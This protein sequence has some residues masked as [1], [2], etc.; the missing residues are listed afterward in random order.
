MIFT[1]KYFSPGSKYSKEASGLPARGER[2]AG[3][4]YLKI[5]SSYLK[6]EQKKQQHYLSITNKESSHCSL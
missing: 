6:S 5:N 1:K 3:V 4:F 2:R